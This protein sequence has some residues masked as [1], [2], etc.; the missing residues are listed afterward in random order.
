MLYIKNMVSIIGQFWYLSVVYRV[1]SYRV[2]GTRYD[3]NPTISANI[4]V[5]IADIDTKYHWSNRY[6]NQDCKPCL[7]PS[8]PDNLHHKETFKEFDLLRFIIKYFIQSYTDM[9]PSCQVSRYS[10]VCSMGTFWKP[11]HACLLLMWNR[12]EHIDVNNGLSTWQ[13]I[14]NWAK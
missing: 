6:W 10:K 1:V 2:W 12:Y 13:F 11:G 4:R 14:H 9:Q 3:I 8:S 5:N 7:Q